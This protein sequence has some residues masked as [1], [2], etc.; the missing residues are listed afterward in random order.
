MEASFLHKDQLE[1][2]E[3]K[4]KFPGTTAQKKRGMQL[5]LA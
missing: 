3:T 5:E 2:N 1:H 4:R